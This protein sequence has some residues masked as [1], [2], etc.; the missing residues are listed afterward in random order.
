LQLRTE[1]GTE[2]LWACDASK[3]LLAVIFQD[4]GHQTGRR[5]PTGFRRRQHDVSTEQGP[6]IQL[7]AIL[8][9]SGHFETWRRQTGSS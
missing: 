7:K 3:K 8:V 1:E 6:L 5:I 4:G 2:F 9:V